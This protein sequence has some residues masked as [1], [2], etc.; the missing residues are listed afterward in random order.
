MTLRW[1]RVLFLSA[2]CV[3]PAPAEEPSFLLGG[4]QVNEPDH[5]H[6]TASLQVSGMNTVEATVYAFQGNWDTDHLWWNDEEP[7]VLDEIRQAR[8]AG[9]HVVLVLR[10]ALDHAFEKNRFLWH[11]QIIPDT[12]ERIDSWFEQYTRFALKWAAIA[13]AEGVSVLALGSEMKELTATLP[14]GRVA[15]IKRYHGF[16]YYQK[17]LRKRALRFADQLSERHYRTR[18]YAGYETLESFLDARHAAN[19]AWAKKAHLRKGGG[20]LRRLNERRGRLLERWRELIAVTRGVFSGKLTYAANFDHYDRVAFWS[21][22]DLVGINSYFSL[23]PH[24]DDR[25]DRQELLE[26][27]TDGWREIFNRIDAFRRDAGIE[28]K[29]VVFTEIGY[30]FRRY[31]TVEPWNHDGFTVVGWKGH[32]RKLV[33]WGEQPVDRSERELAF[34][35]L[36]AVHREQPSRLRGLLYW[37][38]STDV[39]HEEIEP[40]V[41]HVGAASE[42]PA[43]PVLARFD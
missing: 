17:F 27:F 34:R 43:L 37:K 12:P 35:A 15:Q 39:T 10:V 6:W 26:R 38:L 21:E 9:L 18:G 19:M 14:L 7:A 3:S 28:D 31:S 23:R 40:F 36:L 4:I 32:D 33:V 41:L 16:R 24:L 22:L 30:T 2:A 5:R 8:A 1:L 13:E 20:S 29:P 25:P 11:G 42:D